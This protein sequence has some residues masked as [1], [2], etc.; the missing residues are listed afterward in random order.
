MHLELD[1]VS[2]RAAPADNV[3]IATRTLP[4]GTVLRLGTHT[5]T[6]SHTVLEGHRFAF[7][8]LQP[9]DT[10]TSWG[11]AFGEVIRPIEPGDVLCNEAALRELGRRGLDFPLPDHPNFS[12]HIPPFVFDE[13]HFRPAPPLP[14][15]EHGPTF[16]GYRRPGRRGVGTRN[17][18]V[19]LGTTALTGGF[20]RVL[21]AHLK[22]L[23]AQY[24]HIDGIVA[25]AHTEGSTEH[26]NNRDLL[27]RTLAGLI[28]H[29]N[30]GAILIVDRGT[31]AVNNAVLRQYMEQ[32]GYPLAAVPHHF[33][34]LSP[35]F[36]TDVQTAS[37]I[38]RGWL[39]PVNACHRSNEPVSELKIALQC[40]GSDAFSGISGNPLAAW[41]AKEVVCCGGSANLAETDELIGAEAYITSRMRDLETAR[42]FLHFLER[43]KTWTGW[44]HQSA[45]GNPSGG[46][47]YRGLYNIYLK[48]LGAAA[49]M[50]PDLRVDA[51]IDYGEPMTEP[52]F[53]FMD[54]PGNDLES[55]AGQIAAGCNLIFFVTGNGSITNFPFVPTIKIVTTSERYRLLSA[56]MDVNAGAYLDGEP[57]DA[58]G[59]STFALTIAV[60][61]GQLSVGERAGHTQVQIWRDWQQTSA[62]RLPAVA[63]AEYSGQPLPMNA[64]SRV[65]DIRFS[66]VHTDRGWASDQ[67]GL[68]LPTSLCSGQIARMCVDRLNERGVG[69]AIGVSRFVALAHTEGCGASTGHELDNTLIGYLTHPLVKHALLL[70]HGCEKTHNGYWRQA[71]IERG[72]DPAQFGWASVQLD[73]GIQNVMRKMIDWFRQQPQQDMDRGT[74][75]LDSLRVAWVSQGAVSEPLARSLAAFTRLI[76]AAGGTLVLPDADPLLTHP[77]FVRE[78]D[79]QPHITLGYAQTPRA[80]GVHIMDMPTRQW[81]EMLT[82]LGA[83]GVELIIAHIGQQPMF[84][85][86]LIPVLQIT[87]DDPIAAVYAAELDGVFAPDAHLTEHLL[88]LIAAALTQSYVPRL[89]LTGNQD[90]QI[91]RGLLGVSL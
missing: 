88:N 86:P 78:T 50:H 60:A 80:A 53:Y 30:V 51:V 18:I 20:V 33:M 1:T 77:A 89:T 22:G 15:I 19:L 49:K 34:S 59:A 56:E 26:F 3:V 87:T 8:P 68:I 42:R 43:F 47:L 37:A 74:A 64:R 71:L 63:Q 67:V 10:L 2:R 9:G 28:V 35:S 83:G 27:L 25:I 41:V 5:V 14:R 29:P 6:L 13:Q 57:M 4:A 66:L 21:E 32:A 7:Q 44:H 11:Q 79:L 75:G 17:T 46:N 62:T 52:G 85:H 38:V 58:L 45:E 73:G 61:S 55:I 48:S 90:F 65:P 39:E 31:E 76:A 24:R 72:L 81:G 69:Q 70:E 40:G 16:L 84:G 36:Q 82:G 91:T 12:D 54:S 23:A